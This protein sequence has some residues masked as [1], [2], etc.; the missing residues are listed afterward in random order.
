MASVIPEGMR[1][2]TIHTPT[3]EA[4]VAGF[5][6]PGNHVDVLLTM[7]SRGDRDQTG[8]GSTITL[9]QKV[10]V[11]AIEQRV[12]APAESKVDPNQLKSVTLLVSPRAAAK[13]NLGQSKGKLHLALR[14]L[15]DKD[16]AL[17]RP[18]FASELWGEKQT[19]APKVE[20]LA[21]PT[22]EAAPPAPAPRQAPPPP[23]FIRTLR[24]TQE[25]AVRLDPAGN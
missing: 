19:E 4:G 24:G 22:S 23:Q 1:A 25:G 21:A 20:Q 11:L 16:D 10:P 8:G 15:T 17:T 12:V 6:L 13:L 18:V 2:Y 3:V 9:L 14:N 7:E 5:I